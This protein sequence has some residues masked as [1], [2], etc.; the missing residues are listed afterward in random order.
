VET[1]GLKD[2]MQNMILEFYSPR[3]C[4]TIDIDVGDL[5]I[6]IAEQ[7]TKYWGGYSEL[8]LLKMELA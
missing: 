2:S 3:P 1:E 6:A 8:R 5:E 4:T 7:L